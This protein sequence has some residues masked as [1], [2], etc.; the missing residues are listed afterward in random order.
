MGTGKS[1]FAVKASLAILLLFI[2]APLHSQTYNFQ[3]LSVEQGLTQ[4]QVNCIFVDSRG[5]IWAGTAGGGLCLYDGERFKSFEEKDGFAGQIVS[6]ITEDDQGN[7][8]I[9]TTWGGVSKYD[10]SRFQNFTQENGLVSNEIV[11]LSPHSKGKMIIA[12]NKA[13]SLID[14]NRID[15]AMKSEDFGNSTVKTLFKDKDKRLWLVTD[16]GMFVYER[17]EM[18]DLRKKGIPLGSQVN[19]IRQDEKGRYWIGTSNEGIYILTRNGDT[20]S[21]EPFSHNSELKNM[22][23]KAI[24]IDSKKNLWICTYETGLARYNGKE[25]SWYNRENGL[26]VNSI[27]SACSDQFGC[28]W[29]GT[30][31][32]GIVKYNSGAFSYFD[33][34]EGFNSNSIYSVLNAADSSTWVSVFGEGI[35]RYDR[36]GVRKFSTDDGLSNNRIRVLYQDP[37]GTIWCGGRNGLN[38]YRNGK[39]QTFDL[40][41]QNNYVR[42]LAGD[43][44]GNLWIGTNGEGLLRYDGT[45]LDYF[46]EKD[47]LNHNYVHSLFEDSK[48]NLWIGTGNGVNVYRN[49]V[50]DNFRLSTGFCNSYIG[51]I[52]E[53]KAG[54]IWFGT[55]RCIVRYNGSQFKSFSEKNGLTSNTVYLMIVDNEGNL[56]VGTNKGVDKLK[57]DKNGYI[58]TT[59]NYGLAEGFKG[60]ECNAK[61]VSKDAK[62]NLYFG[63]I[64]GLIKFSPEEEPDYTQAPLVHVTGIKLFLKETNWEKKSDNFS[65]YFSLPEELVLSHDEDHLTFHYVG[66][67]HLSPSKIRY[68]CM[69]EGFDREWLDNGNE[70]SIT[71]TNLPAGDYTFKVKAFMSEEG[72]ASVASYTFTIKPAFWRTWWFTFLLMAIFSFLIY[73]AYRIRTRGMTITNKRLEHYVEMRTQEISDQ[74]KKIEILLKE[75]HHRVKNNLQVINSLLNLQSNYINDPKALKVIDECKNRIITMSLIHEKLYESKDFTQLNLKD[76]IMRL[77]NFLKSAYSINP[78]I[79]L[80][81]RISVENVGIDTTV[82]L[83]LLINE[84]MSNSLKYGFDPGQEGK[85][86][87]YL[88]RMQNGKYEMII[89]DNGKGYP[90]LKFDEDLPSFGLE[91][92]KIFTSQLNGQIEKLKEKG[93][94]YRIVFEKI[95]KE[96]D[97]QP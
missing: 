82:T 60:L 58:A 64:K 28:V 72:Q 74:K 95:D 87:I 92:I 59:T 69:L 66:I 18:T 68:R 50:F 38:Y 86:M 78:N 83:G 73:T 37:S 55:D 23:I 19:C 21:M 80:D 63:T 22:V 26:P 96:T 75:I 91:L 33:N 97:K 84:I 40:K 30:G 20:F 71:Y 47:G 12:S 70:T 27:L 16:S 51:S 9:G 32:G 44:K 11:A 57:L 53:D 62:G 52:A 45:R 15:R 93:T 54:N 49:G 14:G 61:A 31:G 39:F 43:S 90:D 10:G 7:M 42:S 65:P 81:L 85:V 6:C 36:T 79:S 13:I 76:Y 77:S 34:L 94:V 8:W 89:G 88:N 24:E 29:F 56:W 35:Y 25:L 4:S 17:H 2:T 48:G 67:N 3:I 41:L 46:T 5:F 1:I